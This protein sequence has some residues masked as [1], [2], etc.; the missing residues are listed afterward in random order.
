MILKHENEGSYAGNMTN[1]LN[2]ADL[3]EKSHYTNANNNNNTAEIR[4][5]GYVAD[6]NSTYDNYN[7]NMLNMQQHQQQQQ[8]SINNLINQ[9]L[10]N[11][12]L[13]MSMQNK[14]IQIAGINSAFNPINKSNPMMHLMNS[15]NIAHSQQ[16]MNL[17]NFSNRTGNFLLILIAFF[18]FLFKLY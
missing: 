9:Q 10:L 5:Q 18:I 16:N 14:N 3:K 15:P 17:V 2:Q 1:T 7:Q 4:N 13:Q 8:N 6:P 12:N 11:E